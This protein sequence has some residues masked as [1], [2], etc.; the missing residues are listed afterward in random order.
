MTDAWPLDRWWAFVKGRK[1]G[2]R[3]KDKGHT[4]LSEL[5]QDL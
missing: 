2:R 1:R 5:Y 4:L 3:E